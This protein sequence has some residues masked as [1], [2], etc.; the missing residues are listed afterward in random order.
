MGPAMALLIDALVM[1]T[2]AN[3]KWLS[4]P[5][6]WVSLCSTLQSGFLRSLRCGMLRGG[7]GNLNSPDRW[8]F[9]ATAAWC[10]ER[11]E[12]HGKTTTPESHRGIQGE[13]GSGRDQGQKSLIEVAQDFDL[14]PNQIKQWRDQLLGRATGVF[15]DGAKAEPEP[16][17]DMNTL[18]ANFGELTPENVFLPGAL[19]KAGLLPSAIR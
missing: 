6:E 3:S 18:H 2:I 10:C 8:I 11:G 13:S 17:I 4:R 14:H 16:V 15:G 9:R 5:H 1:R 19:G 12:D 7:S